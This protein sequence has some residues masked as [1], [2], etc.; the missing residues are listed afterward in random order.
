MVARAATGRVLADPPVAPLDGTLVET[1]VQQA[2]FLETYGTRC[3]S[4]CDCGDPGCGIEPVCGSGYAVVHGPGCGIDAVCGV[5]AGCGIEVGVVPGC[6]CGVGGCQGCDVGCG[7]EE[8]C[9]DGPAYGLQVHG[10][11]SCD[12]CYS[13]PCHDV[14]HIPFCL[15]FLR[16]HWH[17]YDFF[18]GTQG[19]TG[20]MNFA[21]T[22]QSNSNVRSGTGSFGYY[23]GFNQGHSL[24]PWLY[25]DMAMQFGARATQSNL[26]GTT[27]TEQKRYQVFVTAGLFRRVDYG[28]QY[29]L[30]V[31]YLN[32][33]WYYQGDLTQLRG[34][35]SWRGKGCHVCGF[36]F[37][38]GTGDDT[39]TTHIDDGAGNA[40]IDT[41]AF[42][43]TDQ[44]RLFYRRL[45]K[46]NGSFDAFAGWTDNDDGLIGS[47]WNLPIQRCL[48]LS[49]GTTYL[50]PGEGGRRDND[51]ESWNIS[52]GMI[53]RPGGPKG[54][55]RYARPMF[56]VADNG[57]FMID[58]K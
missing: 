49:A 53:Y 46:Q 51:Q 2:G 40:F 47:S 55:G 57:T 20:P 1:K 32:E 38:A 52:L 42:G 12:A 3:G 10:D 7:L 11:C 56:D 16:V 37:M 31:D 25:W 58:R 33:D 24:R 6:D 39:S 14:G 18:A 43:P 45:L 44:Y 5:E 28:L 27:F 26:S 17:R 36:Q 13:D 48:V 23:Q 41:V 35:L 21:N 8:V 15:P 22:D 50:I 19:F 30:V 29:G 54:A 4:V 9:L 34:E